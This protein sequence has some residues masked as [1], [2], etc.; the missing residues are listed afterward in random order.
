[1]SIPS[2]QNLCLSAALADPETRLQI[3]RSTE[4]TQPMR[5]LALK[6]QVEKEYSVEIEEIP[7]VNILFICIIE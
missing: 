6:A 7:E 4:M 1:M 5:K 3:L 2:L